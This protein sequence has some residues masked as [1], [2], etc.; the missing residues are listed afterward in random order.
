MTWRAFRTIVDSLTVPI[1]EGLT[2]GFVGR[3]V[4]ASSRANSSLRRDLP[5]NS[6]DS[7]RAHRHACLRQRV[8]SVANWDQE[9]SGLADDFHPQPSLVPLR[10]GGNANDSLGEDAS[11][12]PEDRRDVEKV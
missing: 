8:L 9:G 5:G 4:I 1:D 3:N 12:R 11:R 7:K 10:I 6:L 2:D